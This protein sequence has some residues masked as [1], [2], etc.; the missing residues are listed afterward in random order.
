MWVSDYCKLCLIESRC[1]DLLYLG[2]GDLIPQ[3]LKYL[4]DVIG[5]SRSEAFTNSYNYVKTLLRSEDPY[6]KVK[7][8]LSAQAVVVAGYVREYLSNHGWDL[9]KALEFSAAANIIDTSVLGFKPR[10]LEDVIWDRPAI[11]EFRGIPEDK[12]VL[13]LDNVGEF[14]VDLILAETLIKNGYEVVLAVRSESY[15]VDI[16][17]N[18]AIK[19]ELPR[20]IKLTTTPGSIPPSTYVKEGFLISKGIA[21]AEAYVESNQHVKSI[22]LL[23]AKC[24]ILSELFSVPK[25]SPLIVSGETLVR[26]HSTPIS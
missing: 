2:R 7:E 4:G 19:R 11:N 1:E 14:E 24:D 25:N 20:G 3:L 23:R 6:L 13:A 15:E 26:M 5:A 12:V 21:N 18:E 9:I 17:Y 22:H 16:T 8:A 10:R